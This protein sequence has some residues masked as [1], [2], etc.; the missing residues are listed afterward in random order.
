MTVTE[1]EELKARA[2]EALRAAVQRCETGDELL[3]LAKAI[4]RKG[5]AIGRYLTG[6]S[7]PPPKVAKRILRVCK[8]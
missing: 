2:V 3:A 8:R 6:F 5:E 4:G 1:R 7:L